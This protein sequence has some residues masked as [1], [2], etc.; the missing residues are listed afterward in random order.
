MDQE[1]L[2][3]IIVEKKRQLLQKRAQ[4]ARVS[5]RIEIRL[6]SQH[7]MGL[8]DLAEKVDFALVFAVVHEVPDP[9]RFFA[10]LFAAIAPSGSV[11]LAEPKGHVSEEEFS[12]TLSTATQQGFTMVKT[13]QIFRSRSVLL[14]KETPPPSLEI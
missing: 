13:L 8:Q 3:K 10:E 1:E 11:L 7:R 14:K 5:G 9:A 12:R 2:R 6:C 4:K